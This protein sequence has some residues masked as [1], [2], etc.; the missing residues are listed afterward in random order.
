MEKLFETLNKNKQTYIIG[1]HGDIYVACVPPVQYGRY[2]LFLVI[3]YNN[4]HQVLEYSI[5]TQKEVEEAITAYRDI[6][7][8]AI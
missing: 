4:N 3:V 7:G 6:I 8:L 2:S 5:C 1:A